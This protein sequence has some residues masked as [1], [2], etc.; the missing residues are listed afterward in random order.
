MLILQNPF[1]GK[2]KFERDLDGDKFDYVQKDMG[3]S[4]GY[5]LHPNVRVYGSYIFRYESEF[6]DINEYEGDGYNAGFSIAGI[7]R[8]KIGLEYQVRNLKETASG[9]ELAGT[10][11]ST[12]YLLTLRLPL[13]VPLP[14]KIK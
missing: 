6:E 4:L 9:T 12:T 14:F 1:Q 5:R 2:G 7:P 3:V 8:V 10:N 11:E 13:P